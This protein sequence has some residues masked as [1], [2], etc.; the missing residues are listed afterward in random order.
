[1]NRTDICVI[2]PTYNNEGALADVIEKTLSQGFHLI[3]VNDGS[4]DGTAELLAGYAS[5]LTLISCPVNRG[6]GFALRQGFAKACEEGFSYAITLDSDGQHSP[7]NIGLFVEKLNETGESL[8]IGNRNV[9][10]GNVPA[11]NTFGKKFSN[12]WF[13]I[14]TWKRCKDTQSGFRLYPL[15]PLLKKHF[16]TDRFEFEVES[17]VRLAWDNIPVHEVDIPVRYFSKENRVS[18]FRP[19]TDFFRIS[20]LNSI[21][22]ILAYLWFLPRLFF[23]KMKNKTWKELFNPEESNLKKAQSLAFGIFMGIIPIWGFQMIAAFA[24]AAVLKLNKTLVLLASN[25]SM[26]VMIPAIVFGSL[27]L[28]SLVLNT[29]DAVKFNSDISLQSVGDMIFQYIIG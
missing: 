26:P 6:K 28:G 12:F 23:L 3:A 14:E 10:I 9:V 1:M 20:V 13:W 24:L 17:L 7:E 27:W 18:H 11:K 29:G 21:L 15:R 4:T 2:I 22:V 19:A 8:I 5:H 16:Y 25:I